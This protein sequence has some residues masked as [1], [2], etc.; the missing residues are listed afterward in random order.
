MA[1]LQPLKEGLLLLLLFEKPAEFNSCAGVF[2][3]CALLL[4]HHSTLK[5][6]IAAWEVELD[7]VT[8]WEG[9]GLGMV[10]YKT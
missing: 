2:Q 6:K 5:H 9:F 10:V 8:C 4:L 1:A 7:K 3:L